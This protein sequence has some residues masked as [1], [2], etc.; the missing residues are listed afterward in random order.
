MRAEDKH[1]EA[2]PRLHNVKATEEN[3]SFHILRVKICTLITV[4]TSM[5]E[6]WCSSFIGLLSPLLAGEATHHT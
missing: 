1:N 5:H 3:W 6:S 2:G 4:V